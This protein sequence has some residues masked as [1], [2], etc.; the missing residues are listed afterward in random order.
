MGTIFD[1][2]S[3][4][5]TVACYEV[6]M[7]SLLPQIYLRDF[8]DFFSRHYFRFLDDVFHKR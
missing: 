2:V 4:N 6:K 1:V 3:S 5:L 7:F 8:V